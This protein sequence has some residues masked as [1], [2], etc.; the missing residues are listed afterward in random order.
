MR[1]LELVDADVARLARR[2]APVALGLQDRIGSFA[3]GRE[4][5]LVVID[6]AAT[7]LL[8]RRLRHAESLAEKL[9]ALV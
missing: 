1:A 5:D 6:L 9:F 4:A 3:P 2:A 7:P 8:E